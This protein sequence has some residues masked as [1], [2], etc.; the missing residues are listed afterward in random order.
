MIASYAIHDLQFKKPAKTSR[1]TLETKRLYLLQVQNKDGQIGYGEISPFEGLSMDDRPNFDSKLNETIALINDGADLESLDL[2]T[3]PS[4]AF[5]YDTAIRDLANGGKRMFFDGPFAEGKSSIEINGLVWMASK[6]EMLKQV[7][8]KI[9]QGFRCIKMKIG[10]LDF[11][12]ECRMLEAIRKTYSAFQ[13]ELRVDANGAFPVSDAFSMLKDL[14]RFD[15]H[16]IE[17]PIRQGQWEEMAELCAKSPL[18]IALD[19]ELLGINAS[20]DGARMLKTISPKYLIIKP[21]LLGAFKV[22]TE[23]IKQAHAQNT[24]WWI[25]SAL[26]SN[27]GLAAIAQFTSNYRNPLPQGLGTGQLYTNNFPSPLRIQQGRLDQN[28][29]DAWN[30]NLYLPE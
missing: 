27:L 5:G 7:E 12:E 3:W 29:S 14:N 25:T 24:A 26:E 23:W 15:L 21:G 6:E 1:N 4:I 28:G 16:S 22:S 9:T 2:E 30:F 13:I 20:M 11:D 19:E 8:E 18:D 17:Q 10:A